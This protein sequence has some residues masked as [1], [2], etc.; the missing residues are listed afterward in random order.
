M[1]FDLGFKVMVYLEVKY[2]TDGATFELNKAQ[3]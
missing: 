2:L 1:T 3:L